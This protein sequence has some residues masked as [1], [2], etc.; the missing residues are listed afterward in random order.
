MSGAPIGIIYPP[1][2]LRNIVDKTAGFV[3]N[4]KNGAEFESRIR[5]N[6]AKNPKF[7]FLNPGD[8][9]NAYY[10]NKVRELRD[11]RE[12]GEDITPKASTT[13]AKTTEEIQSRESELA[14]RFLLKAPSSFDF[15]TDAPSLEAREI[16][17][18][19]LTAQFVA[20]HGRSFLNNLMARESKNYEFDFIRPQHSLFNYFS[21]LTQQYSRIIKP[22]DNIVEDL[23]WEASHPKNILDR[24]RHRL[25][26]RLKD[27]AEKSRNME[28]AEKERLSYASIDWHDFVVVE[29]VDYQANEQGIFPPPTTPEQVGKRILLIQRMEQQGMEDEVEMDVEDNVQEEELETNTQEVQIKEAMLPPPLP[30]SLESA[31]IRKDY[32]P[33][34]KV[35]TEKKTT[36]TTS[37]NAW[38]ISPITGQKIPAEKLEEHMR[39]GLLDPRW[40]QE[41]EKTVTDKTHEEQ[42]FAPGTSIESSLRQL[43]ERRTDIFGSGVEETSIG[44]KI[45]MEREEQKDKVIWDGYTSSAQSAI[46]SAQ[47]KITMED[48]IQ[49]MKRRTVPDPELEKIGPKS[50]Q[51]SKHTLETRQPPPHLPPPSNQMRHP[52]QPLLPSPGNPFILPNPINPL[53]YPMP[54]DPSMIHAMV[55][56]LAG[57]NPP[58]NNM[59]ESSS[60]PASKKAKTEESLIPEEDFLKSSP[61]SVNITISCPSVSDKNDWNL[62]GQS[63]SVTFDI[64]DTI[65]SVKNKIQSMTSMPPSKQKLQLQ[66]LFLKDNNSLAFYNMTNGSTI[67]LLTKERGGRKK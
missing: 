59:E 46:I 3:A 17:I 61:A 34:D 36:D 39:Y 63:L 50:I 12:R 15:S 22:P 27:E 67:Q 21:S 43:A 32:N 19:K 45:G 35:S 60:E 16:E 38:V 54:P 11:A 18:V 6:E 5:E 7:N 48:K 26:W 29:T 55:S 14:T 56:Q 9:Y 64:R 66:G 52:M 20:I 57:I 2:E 33:R 31:V 4:S 10:V 49:D 41:R 53:M 37:S 28:E 42:V 25:E 30:L 8:P 58:V 24:V 65:V 44:S 23:T 40:L 62:N 1:P 51:G 47:S 13:S